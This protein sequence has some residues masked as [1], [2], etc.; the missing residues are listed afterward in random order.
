MFCGTNVPLRN[1][2]RVAASV[3]PFA[4]ASVALPFFYQHDAGLISTQNALSMAALFVGNFASFREVTSLMSQQP[5]RSD[6]T[7]S[8]KI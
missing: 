8:P 3:L 4:I 7:N 6:I 2:I 5:H 1:A